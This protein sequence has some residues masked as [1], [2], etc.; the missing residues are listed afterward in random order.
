M[1]ISS[2]ADHLT[3]E[4]FE[5]GETAAPRGVQAGSILPLGLPRTAGALDSESGGRLRPLPSPAPVRRSRGVALSP[6]SSE[7]VDFA[8]PRLRTRRY[9]HLCLRGRLAQR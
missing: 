8:L 2:D 4:Y 7:R 9:N 6:A 1:G 3:T 5:D